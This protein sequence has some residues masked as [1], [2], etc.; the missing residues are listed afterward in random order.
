MQICG[1]FEAKFG[2]K[3]RKKGATKATVRTCFQEMEG[4]PRK[5]LLIPAGSQKDKIVCHLSH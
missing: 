3:L 4:N 1:N 5:K 2:R